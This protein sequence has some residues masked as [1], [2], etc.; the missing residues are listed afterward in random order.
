MLVIVVLCWPFDSARSASF[1]L[2]ALQSLQIVAFSGD[3]ILLPMF[4][5]PL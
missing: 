3:L 5:P 4:E 2:V 1:L